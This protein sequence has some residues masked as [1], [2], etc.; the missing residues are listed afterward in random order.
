MKKYWIVAVILITALLLSV[1]TPA[2]QEPASAAS[3]G[4]LKITI[5]NKSSQNVT[6]QMWGPANYN[7]LAKKSV[8]S[9]HNVLPG[10]YTYLYTVCG[11]RITGEY[12][13]TKNSKPLTIPA[14]AQIRLVNSTGSTMW[15]RLSGPASYSFTLPPGK[16]NLSVLSGTYQYTVTG[17]GGISKSGKVVLKGKKTW[18]WWCYR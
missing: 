11:A 9:K 4:T 2:F 10:K 6:V 5:K 3:G 14:C 7:L 15:L 12:V 16:T 18:V 8:A 13:A 17:C 1:W